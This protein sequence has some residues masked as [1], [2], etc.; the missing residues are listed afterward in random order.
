MSANIESTRESYQGALQ[1]VQ[2]FSENTE[3]QSKS[4]D[5]AK[6]TVLAAHQAIA[7]GMSVAQ[8]VI[9][10][11][12]G[13]L[14]QLAGDIYLSE[15]D[16]IMK[17]QNLVEECQRYEETIK[18]LQRIRN[19]SII[20]DSAA[21]NKAIEKYKTLLEKTKVELELMKGLLEDLREKATLSQELFQ[22]AGTLLKEVENAINDAEF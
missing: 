11:H 19:Y 17:I 16:L 9:L 5:V 7:V 13:E 4:W 10:Q 22:V 14:E 6:S 15:D 1:V 8:E 2:S 12:A 21:I 3:L 20:K 18:N